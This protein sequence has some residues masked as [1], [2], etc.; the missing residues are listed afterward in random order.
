MSKYLNH[1]GNLVA[2]E[3]FEPSFPPG[4]RGCYFLRF[5]TATV[6]QLLTILILSLP[7]AASDPWDTTEKVLYG[8]CLITSGLDMIS[9]HKFQGEGYKEWNPILGE[10]PSDGKLAA[11]WVGLAAV[12]C[13]VADRLPSK[14]WARKAYLFVVTAAHASAARHNTVECGLTWGF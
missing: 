5:F 11:Y 12:H 9:T 3:G 7:A 8:T 4:N 14:W 1:Y 6:L 2:E 13:L 10:Q